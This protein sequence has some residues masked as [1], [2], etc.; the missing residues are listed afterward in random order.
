MQRGFK[1]LVIAG[2]LTSPALTQTSRAAL[3][4]TGGVLQPYA[5]VPDGRFL[6]SGELHAGPAPAPGTRRSQRWQAARL[7]SLDA[8]IERP[9]ARR[10]DY[11]DHGAEHSAWSARRA[12]D[13]R[14]ER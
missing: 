10:G 1:W 2:L 14:G 4:T 9:A 7:S 13:T 11:L 5:G 6:D 3:D 8:L 12:S